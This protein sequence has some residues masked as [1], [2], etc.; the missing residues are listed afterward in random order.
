[1]WQSMPQKQQIIKLSNLLTYEL[2]EAQCTV[3]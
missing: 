1:M 3:K 2:H